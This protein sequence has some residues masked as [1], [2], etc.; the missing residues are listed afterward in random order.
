[1]KQTQQ[2]EKL[3]LD[4]HVSSLQLTFLN[5][6]KTIPSWPQLA[7]FPSLASFLHED[8]KITL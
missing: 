7:S 6:H 4:S 8:I 1:M 5:N 3:T 2:F